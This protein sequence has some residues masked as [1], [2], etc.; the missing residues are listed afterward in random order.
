MRNVAQNIEINQ[1]I[2]KIYKDKIRFTLKKKRFY[3]F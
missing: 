1:Q 2:R 3:M